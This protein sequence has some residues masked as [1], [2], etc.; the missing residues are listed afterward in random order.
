MNVAIPLGL[1]LD[2]KLSKFSQNTHCCKLEKLKFLLNHSTRWLVVSYVYSLLQT[3]D[4]LVSCFLQS[5][6]FALKIITRRYEYLLI[7]IWVITFVHTHKVD[8]LCTINHVSCTTDHLV[9]TIYYLI[10]TISLN[11]NIWFIWYVRLIESYV[12]L[13]IYVRL[14]YIMILCTVPNSLSCT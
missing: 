2:N 13:N 14:L 11:K 8:V 3:Y 10:H 5:N 4:S 9:R 7:H 1:Y 6:H 12:R